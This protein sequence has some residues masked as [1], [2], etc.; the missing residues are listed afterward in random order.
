M[1]IEAEI[2][3]LKVFKFNK[4]VAMTMNNKTSLKI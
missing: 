4:P 3:N 1:I 2:S